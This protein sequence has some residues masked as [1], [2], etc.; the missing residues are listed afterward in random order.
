MC[1]MKLDRGGHKHRA[2][3]TTDGL[4]RED[5]RIPVSEVAELLDVS[6]GSAHAVL[7]NTAKCVPDESRDS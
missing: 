6:C 3:K 5:R 4:I 7:Q 2:V 1:V